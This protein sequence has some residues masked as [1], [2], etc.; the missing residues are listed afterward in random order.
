MDFSLHYESDFVTMW[1]YIAVALS[2]FV[3]AVLLTLRK[4]RRGLRS[5]VAVMVLL[6]LCALAAFLAYEAYLPH[7][8]YFWY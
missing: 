7:P 2:F 6:V 1:F 5:G 3:T 4:R 8:R